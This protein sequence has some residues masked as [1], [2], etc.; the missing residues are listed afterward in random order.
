[1]E[2]KKPRI[3]SLFGVIFAAIII[4]AAGA[5][6]GGLGAAPARGGMSRITGRAVVMNVPAPTGTPETDWQNIQDAL[7]AAQPGDIVQLAAGHYK[8]HRQ[9]TFLGSQTYPIDH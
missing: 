5:A 3:L 8:I 4:V 1:M 7:D 6:L 9:W 2:R